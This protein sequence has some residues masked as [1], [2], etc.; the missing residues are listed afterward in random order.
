MTVAI[1]EPRPPGI[2][3]AAGA[4][5]ARDPVALA[6]LMRQAGIG[7]AGMAATAGWLSG[8]R[9]QSGRTQ[10]GYVEDLSRWVA[11]CMVRGIDPAAAPA[12]AADLF[13]KS[14]RDA[15]LASATRAR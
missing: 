11:W 9:R 5:P 4:P 10:A 1:P 6:A 8:E 3:P 12:T 7:E 13:A 2:R 15:G 14:M